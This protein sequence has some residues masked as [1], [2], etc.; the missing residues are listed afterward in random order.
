VVLSSACTIQ[1]ALKVHFDLLQSFEIELSE[2]GNIQKQA[3]SCVWFV[4]RRQSIC[5]GQTKLPEYIPSTFESTLKS[6]GQV[7][8]RDEPK[9]RRPMGTFLTVATRTLREARTVRRFL[10]R[11]RRG[12]ACVARIAPHVL[13]N[14]GFCRNTCPGAYLDRSVW[15]T[16]MAG[17]LPTF[18]KDNRL[19]GR[20]R[21]QESFMRGRQIHRASHKASILLGR[22]AVDNL[23]VYVFQ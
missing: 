9:H 23:Q 11:W 10:P 12:R 1:P 19:T 22:Q 21:R 6:W 17:Q 14:L 15:D 8:S 7:F 13:D 16:H 5:S 20:K 4:R 3:V 18:G 2:G